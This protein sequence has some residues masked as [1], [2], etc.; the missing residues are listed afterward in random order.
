[1][2]T[3]HS[4]LVLIYLLKYVCVVSED[5]TDPKYIGPLISTIEH[6]LDYEI[7]FPSFSHKQN[8]SKRELLKTKI[9]INNLYL[10]IKVNEDVIWW[11]PEIIGSSGEPIALPEEDHLCEYKIGQV[12]GFSESL[13]AVS[14]CGTQITGLIQV[15]KEKIYF[16]E[17]L[18]DEGLISTAHLLYM[19]N[20]GKNETNI[21]R[22]RESYLRPLDDPPTLETNN[23]FSEHFS[24]KDQE[25]FTVGND[26]K[27]IFQDEDSLAGYFV[28]PLWQKS[29]KKCKLFYII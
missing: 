16:V 8:R 7:V 9:K 6:S 28:D 19:P 26:S 11:N 14:Q 1:M 18:T 3:R 10:E 29:S 12:L 22:K 2:H 13:V 20:V 17:P 24:T 21:R 25:F 27:Q 4:L 23:E 5:F 15:N